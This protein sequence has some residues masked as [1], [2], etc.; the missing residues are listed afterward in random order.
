[1]KEDISFP[2]STP[3]VKLNSANL[4]P[5]PSP[6]AYPSL[7]QQDDKHPCFIYTGGAPLPQDFTVT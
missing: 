2:S 3:Q 6:Q 1:M 4:H 5:P 7:P